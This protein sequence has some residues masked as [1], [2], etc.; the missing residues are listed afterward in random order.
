M[1]L[2]GNMA[3]I[4]N[5]MVLNTRGVLGNIGH[6]CQVIIVWLLVCRCA[7]LHAEF[8]VCSFVQILWG[9]WSNDRP[10]ECARP[11]IAKHYKTEKTHK[12]QN[13]A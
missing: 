8:L 2:D 13:M 6:E 7:G 3:P 11:G 1:N 9:P 5:V 12:G 10:R 4:A